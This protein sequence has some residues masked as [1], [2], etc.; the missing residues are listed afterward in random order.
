[1]TWITRWYIDHP[2]W[3]ALLGFLVIVVSGI[4][5]YLVAVFGTLQLNNDSWRKLIEA[6]NYATQTVTT[7]GYGNMSLDLPGALCDA[8]PRLKFFS[9]GYTIVAVLA[10]AL[11]VDRAFGV[12]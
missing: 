5:V 10:W 12:R 7:V 11:V 2:T 4:G 8:E 1:M 6:T 9:S 3:F